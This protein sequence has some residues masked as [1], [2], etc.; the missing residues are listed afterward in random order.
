MWK[1]R[2]GDKNIIPSFR[3]SALLKRGFKLAQGRY[4]S[5]LSGDDRFQD[6]FKFQKQIEFL[7]NNVQY[8]ACYSDFEKF[9][10]D[11]RNVPM[12]YC[13]DCIENSFGR[14]N[15]HTFRALHSAERC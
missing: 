15:M 2:D 8:A 5:I 4:L 6:P 13:L 7:N 1:E 9:W 14:R 10:D 3:V 12:T 11:G